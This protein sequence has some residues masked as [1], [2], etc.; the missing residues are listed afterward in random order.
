[1]VI[2][3]I[4]QTSDL[5]FL[6]S[7]SKIKTTKRGTFEVDALSLATNVAGIFAGGDIRRGA[8]LMI[9]AMADGRRAAT[10]IDCYLQGNPLPPEPEQPYI[11]DITEPA[12]AF[13]LRE[14]PKEA[15]YKTAATPVKERKGAKEVN[16]GFDEKTCIKEARRCLTCRCTSIRY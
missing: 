6:G 15:R 2:T 3:A 11:A 8:G 4:G 1:M 10:A 14:E 12:M 5:S 7:D 16:L 9:E 13:H